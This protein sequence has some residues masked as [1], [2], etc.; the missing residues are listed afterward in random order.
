MKWKPK[1]YWIA[2]VGGPVEVGGHTYAGLG[3][4][5]KLSMLKRSPQPPLWVLSHIGSGHRVLFIK[6]PQEK[7][8]EIATEVAEMSDWAFYGLHGWKNMA[9]GIKEKILNIE[10]IHKEAYRMNGPAPASEEQ[11]R[12]IM[13]RQITR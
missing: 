8:I 1:K 12:D 13:M 9:P 6:A 4:H 5:L 11:A 2:T 10:T 3:L 7:A